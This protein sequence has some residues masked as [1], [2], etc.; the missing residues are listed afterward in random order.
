LKDFKLLAN[1]RTQGWEKKWLLFYRYIAS[2]NRLQIA[3][4]DELHSFK[5]WSMGKRNDF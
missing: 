4:I 2:I 3:S 1:V 5:I